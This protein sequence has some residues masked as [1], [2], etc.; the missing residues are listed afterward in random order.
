M[1]KLL[2][3]VCALSI[4]VLL[5]VPA[6]AEVQNIKVDGALGFKA[7]IRDNY[8]VVGFQ[9]TDARDWYSNYA[10]V[11]FTADLTDNVTA[12]VGM[13]AERDWGSP[14]D[15][16]AG[17]TFSC[18]PC[19]VSMKEMLYSPLTLNVGRMGLSIADALVIGDGSLTNSLI[20]SDYSE[21]T[22]FDT[23]HGILDYDPLK[24]I[25][26]TAKISD[27]IQ[28]STDDVD[29]Y[30]IDGIYTM[31]EY[32]AVL[33]TYLVNMH[34]SSPGE[35]TNEK[36]T[37]IQGLTGPSES[38]TQGLDVYTLATSL[39]MEPAEG[40]TT[41]LGIALQSGDYEKTATTTR[42]L[43]AYALDLGVNYAVDAEYSPNVGV[44]YIYRSGDKG[45]KTGVCTG[46]YKGWLPLYGDQSNG[47]I[48]DP[49]TNTNSI[50]LTAG[51]VP[52]D[53]LDVGLEVWMYNLAKKQL[54]ATATSTK[55]DAGMEI[56]LNA[57]YAYTEDVSMGLSFAW[58]M[59]GD[60]YKTGYDET[61]TQVLAEIGIKF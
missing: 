26:G 37:K 51:L 23:I 25:I 44:K 38:S 11:K 46:D 36:G 18:V 32:N 17:N 3:G 49:N 29:L 24:L 45:C 59:P 20:A 27:Q 4:A 34:Y 30:F 35:Y 1:K 5:A 57:V 55:T 9:D 40:L 41:K 28:G 8:E 6:F 19:Y 58:F 60:Y 7:F 53:R 21:A 2:T 33:D 47:T 16:E 31:E 14:T 61:A 12:V 13:F 39:T 10:K 42:D 52:V 56:D 50:C 48:Y 43:N 54:D 22:T 15:G